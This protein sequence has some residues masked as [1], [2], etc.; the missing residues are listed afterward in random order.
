[1]KQ[2]AGQSADAKLLT[3]SEAAR[4]LG[5]G[6]TTFYALASRLQAKGL[7]FV[8]IPSPSGKTPTRRYVAASIDRIIDETLRPEKDKEALLC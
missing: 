4:R 2:L 1:M 8:M 5:M 3:A 6:R 7:R